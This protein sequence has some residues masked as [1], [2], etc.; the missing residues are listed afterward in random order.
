M[1]EHGLEPLMV[2]AADTAAAGREALGAALAQAPDL[3]AVLAMN[4]NAIF[5]I[6]GGLSTRG[7]RVPDDISVVSMVTSPQVAELATPALTAM[8]SPGSTMVRLAVASLLEILDGQG[9]PPLQQ[10]VPC[11][12]EVRGSSGPARRT[13]KSP[14]T[15]GISAAPGPGPPAS[16]ATTAARRRAATRRRA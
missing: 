5:G 3:T 11:A 7:L 15:K 6:L 12:L 8:T 4:E 9:G 1:R 13:S 14:R 2:P 16:S 10:L